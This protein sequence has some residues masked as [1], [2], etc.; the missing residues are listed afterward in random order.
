MALRAASRNLKQLSWLPAF[1]RQPPAPHLCARLATLA[2]DLDRIHLEGLVFHGYHGV[3]PEVS[4]CAWRTGVP[5]PLCAACM[6]RGQP[7]S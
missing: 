2:D 4:W 3:Y 6:P 1:L 7:D 5:A